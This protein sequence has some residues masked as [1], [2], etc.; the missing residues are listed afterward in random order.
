LPWTVIELNNF[1]F[2]GAFKSERAKRKRKSKKKR[3]ETLKWP[4]EI[5]GKQNAE[6]YLLSFLI[7]SPALKSCFCWAALEVEGL[8]VLCPLTSFGDIVPRRIATKTKQKS[9]KLHLQLYLPNA[10]NAGK[11]SEKIGS[12]IAFYFLCINL[13]KK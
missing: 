4:S 5:N 13:H 6:N 10:V 9:C 2:R 1:S 12:Q 7:V 8:R 11:H 3:P